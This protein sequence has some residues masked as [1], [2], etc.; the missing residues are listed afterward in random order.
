MTE[1]WLRN[2][3]RVLLL[4]AVPP[5]LPAILG[6]A[7]AFNSA[8]LGLQLAGWGLW[9]LACAGWGVVVWQLFRPRV[10]FRATPGPGQ[11]WIYLRWAGVIR[12]PIEFVEG[13]LLGQGP[14]LLPL[15]ASE[16]VETSTLV[17][18]VADSAESFAHVEV[19]RILGSWCNHYVTIRGMWC[20]P[21]SVGLVNRLNAQ[22]AAVT[23]KRPTAQ[24]A[25]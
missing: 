17:I 11:L 9:L 23:P 6:L 7:L 24:A 15:P 14:T 2:N 13:F 19:D 8:G 22:L 3:S 12:V 10:S 21:L 18:K 16:N 20:E 5:A 25:R 4:A 1:I